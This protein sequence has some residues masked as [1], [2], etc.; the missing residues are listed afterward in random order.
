MGRLIN[1]H[2]DAAFTFRGL[3]QHGHRLVSGP[4]KRIRFPRMLSDQVFPRKVGLDLRVAVAMLAHP[5]DHGVRIGT[6]RILVAK[7]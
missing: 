6:Q 7:V 1:S 3:N 5:A 4:F 2:T